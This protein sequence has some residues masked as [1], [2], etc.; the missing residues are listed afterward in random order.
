MFDPRS[1]NGRAPAGWPKSPWPHS[2]R[3]DTWSGSPA[4]GKRRIAR[5]CRAMPKYAFKLRIRKGCEEEYDRE[6]RRV[7]PELLAKLKAVGISDYSIFRRDQDLV[8][9][10]RV[11]NFDEAWDELDRDPV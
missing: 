7:W 1:G 2:A 3:A 4:R 9:T 10:L 11:E 8:L 5:R 6:H